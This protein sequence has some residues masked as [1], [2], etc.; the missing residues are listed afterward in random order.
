MYPSALALCS[1]EDS[2]NTVTYLRSL[3]FFLQKASGEED[4]QLASPGGL[5]GRCSA[6]LSNA[7]ETYTHL[8]N[9]GEGRGVP[10]QLFNHL[11][12]LHPFQN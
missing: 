4:M 8:T 10:E 9:F 11:S 6:P 5:L 1:G 2:L 12:P 7:H 3:F